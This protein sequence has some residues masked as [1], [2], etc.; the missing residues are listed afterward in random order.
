MKKGNKSF[1]KDPKKNIK[2]EIL[3]YLNQDGFNK[4]YLMPQ[5]RGLVN[6]QI[7]QKE[8]FRIEHGV[9][10]YMTNREEIV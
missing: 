1:G 7:K 9:T 8:M 2:I 5:K 6:S 10:K 3:N 4:A